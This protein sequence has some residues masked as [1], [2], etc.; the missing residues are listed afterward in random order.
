MYLQFSCSQLELFNLAKGKVHS[1]QPKQ[2][3]D[4]FIAPP[5]GLLKSP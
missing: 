2:A 4:S 5:T 1:K 3:L